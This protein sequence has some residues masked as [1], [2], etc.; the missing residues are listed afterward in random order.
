MELYARHAFILAI[1]MFKESPR[2]HINR[3][4]LSSRSSFLIPQ[5]FK[6]VLKH[7]DQ[8]IGLQGFL[9]SVRHSVNE[10]VQF[11]RDRLILGG[12]LLHLRNKVLRVILDTS[13]D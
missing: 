3:A 13:I 4:N 1:I 9:Y 10:F 8:L 6:I 7:I 5:H 11:L 12:V 2:E